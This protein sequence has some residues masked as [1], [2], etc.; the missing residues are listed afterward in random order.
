MKTNKSNLN[1][2]ENSNNKPNVSVE[3]N[4]LDLKG[5]GKRFYRERMGEGRFRS[6]TITCKD[7]DL[8]IGIDPE[9][10]KFEMI[11]YAQKKLFELRYKLESYISENSQFQTSFIPVETKTGD[12]YIAIEMS[13]AS[14]IAGTGPMASVAGAFSEYIGKTIQKQFRIEEIVVENGGDIYFKLRKDLVLSVYAGESPL[15]GKIGVEIPASA[16]PLGICT[17]AGTVGPSISF[18]KADAVMIASKNTALAD[19]FATAYGNKVKRAEDIEK[20]LCEVKLNK[21]IL[22]TVIICEGKVGILGQ[23]KIKSIEFS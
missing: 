4:R 18:G 22:S 14:K 8:W 20:V 12:P 7:S 13:K 16:T 11:E 3:K 2:F 9:N 19:A 21:K 10:F 6:F 1:S 17:S 23:F 15:S 5:F